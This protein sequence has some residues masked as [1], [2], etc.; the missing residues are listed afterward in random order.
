[1]NWL[2]DLW[3]RLVV[4]YQSTI[5]GLVVLVF[6]WA[7]DHGIDVSQDNQKVATAKILAIAL[8]VL[9]LFGKDAPAPVDPPPSTGSGSSGGVG[10]AGRTWALVA[11]LIAGTLTQTACGNATTLARVGA[12]VVQVSKG[13]TAEAASL[14]ASGLLTPA[15]LDALDKKA[16]A[17]EVSAAA[18]QSYLNSLPGV[19]AGNKAE[20]VSKV[21]ETL[22]LVS[23]LA[24]NA[25][26]IGLPPDNLFVKILTFGNITLQNV[27]VVLAALNPPAVSVSSVGGE[28][29]IPL[30]KIKV[31]IAP[32]PKGA[33]KYFQ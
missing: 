18:L 28:A 5:T 13:I 7:T 24:Q 30:H 9:K 2:S 14:R 25:D 10:P 29:S 33:E 27:S 17:I 4:N 3:N 26:V 23:A 8:S 21:G 15:K 20:V 31:Q 11:L 12:T 19:N 16:K 22:S 6:T 1:M 32:V